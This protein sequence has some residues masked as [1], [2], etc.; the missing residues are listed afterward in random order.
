MARIVTQSSDKDGFVYSKPYTANGNITAGHLVMLDSSGK[1]VVHAT[2]GGS[3]PRMFAERKRD[4]QSGFTT[5]F[6]TGKQV[7][8]VHC[9][10]GYELNVL[11]AAGA[12]AIVKGDLLESAGDGTLR[13]RSGT[14]DVVGVALAAVDNSGGGTVVSLSAVIK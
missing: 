11:L 13:K 6:T 10:P 7:P 1:V 12:S 14:N 8:V 5:A 2:A 4:T 9:K 3:T